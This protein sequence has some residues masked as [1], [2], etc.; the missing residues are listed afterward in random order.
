MKRENAA[1]AVKLK[2]TP[3]NY[4]IYVM[5]L[6]RCCQL[7]QHSVEKSKWLR[8]VTLHGYKK[9]EQ[10]TDNIEFGWDCL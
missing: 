2:K 9:N 4:A 1:M 6:R 7:M 10:V 5:A 8:F 3:G